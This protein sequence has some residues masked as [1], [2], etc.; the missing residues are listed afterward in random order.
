MPPQIDI[1]QQ[2]IDILRV[3]DLASQYS[4][5]LDKFLYTIFF[6]VI[7]LLLII[8]V[9]SGKIFPDHK[10]LSVLLGVSFVIFIMVYP[11]ESDYSLYSAF[12]PIGAVWYA[13]VIIIGVFWILLGRIWPHGREGGAVARR[14]PGVL[15]EE[16]TSSR[17]GSGL[18]RKIEKTHERV[19]G[20]YVE[21]LERDIIS[22]LKSL[23]GMI[24]DK[25]EALRSGN[26]KG[27]AEL[28]MEFRA[29]K[30]EIAT[31][32]ID[33][34]NVHLDERRYRQ[35]DPKHYKRRINEIESRFATA[36]P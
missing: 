17:G 23:E 12:A 26:T 5:A 4:S 6:P 1:L 7:L 25:T 15:D 35:R 30:K 16:R 36:R 18:W 22:S 11:P 20:E 32:I 33:F 34:E 28:R 3:Q 27:V 29:L 13:F 14:M 31:K 10:G 19:S 21:Q 24:N 8:F 9:L 2:I